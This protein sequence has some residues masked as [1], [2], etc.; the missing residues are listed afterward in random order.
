MSNKNLDLLKEILFILESSNKS[1]K[2]RLDEEESKEL[3]KI[4]LRKFVE[5]EDLDYPHNKTRIYAIENQRIKNQ[6]GG[7]RKKKVVKR[8]PKCMCASCRRR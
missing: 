5:R 4:R 1:E 7:R 3:R 8:K 2:Q 6:L